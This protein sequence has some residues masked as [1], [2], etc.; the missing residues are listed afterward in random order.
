[1]PKNP[2]SSRSIS[3]PT[4]IVLASLAL[5]VGVVG[6][7]RSIRDATVSIHEKV[8]AAMSC[9]HALPMEYELNDAS[10]RTERAA[11]IASGVISADVV[12][13]IEKIFLQKISSTVSGGSVEEIA[14]ISTYNSIY[15]E[16]LDLFNGL[17][18]EKLTSAQRSVVKYLR[19]YVAH[20]SLDL[21]RR[22]GHPEGDQLAEAIMTAQP[23]DDTYYEALTNGQKFHPFTDSSENYFG[24]A[25][26]AMGSLV[27]GYVDHNRLNLTDTSSHSIVSVSIVTGGGLLV[28]SKR[29][30]QQIQ[31]KNVA[32]IYGENEAY[33]VAQPADGTL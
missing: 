1:M 8:D 26:E 17:P 6:S 18:Y 30:Y 20:H 19:F 24:S 25:R 3:R 28:L 31:L 32:V 15:P 16:L 7:G 11:I 9:D 12:S 21:A 2:T 23:N 13:K 22:C 14:Q 4:A 27:A 29:D 5:S 33:A 10:V